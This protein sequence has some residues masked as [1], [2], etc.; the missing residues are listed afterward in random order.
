MGPAEGEGMVQRTN[1]ASAPRTG[2]GRRLARPASVAAATLMASTGIAALATGGQSAEAS[3]SSGST[4][5]WALNAAPPTLFGPTDFSSENMDI[6]TLIYGT[7]LTYSTTGKLEPG[8]VSSWQAVN[9]TTYVYHVRPGVKFSNGDPVTAADVAYSWN[10]QLNTKL[11][12]KESYLVDGVTSITSSAS[13]VTVRLSAPDALWQYVP[14]SIVGYVYDEASVDKNLMN[15][16]TPST[17]PVGAGPYM[18]SSDN[19]DSEI[20]LVRNPNYYGTPGRYAKV[21]FDVIPDSATML[22]ALQRGTID[23]TDN[24][25]TLL[26][27]LSK[28]ATTKLVPEDIWTGLTLDMSEKPFNNLHVREAL[29][30]ATDRPALLGPKDD[31]TGQLATTVNDPSIF[32]G[33][34]PKATVQ[35]YYDKIESFPYNLAEAKKQLAESPV[36]HGFTATLNVP[37]DDPYDSTA[38][39]ILQADWG[40]IGVKLNLKLMPGSP[41]FQI[42]LDH[43]PN[44][45]IQIIGNDPDGPDPVEMAQEYFSIEQAAKGGNNSSN[46]KNATVNE[47]LVKAN[48]STNPAVSARLTL[49]AQ[50]LA[51]K[52]VPIIPFGLGD[53]VMAV[54]KGWT[55]GALSSFYN[56]TDWVDAIHAP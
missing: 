46:Y 45:G 29:Y 28:D 44:L 51:S 39:E 41:R 26:A 7:A 38:G 47:L 42:I 36:P 22:L 32:Y 17:V 3:T 56:T 4:L 48:S 24:S 18:V 20:T 54:H 15:Y 5:T 40:Q 53:G 27:T 10:L 2:A 12:S 16:G 43:G 6:M 1:A 13:T 11:A 37:E 34:L 25:S 23:G 52:A 19:P 50:V 55:I 8:I 35:S 30:L 31:Q 49:E 21:V 33:A 9:P 14:A